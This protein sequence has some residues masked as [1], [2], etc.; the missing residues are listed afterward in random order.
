MVAFSI[1]L[2]NQPFING[3]TKLLGVIGDPVE[4]SL[5]PVMHNAAIAHLGVNYIYLPFPV[6]QD[7]LATALDGFAAIGVQGINLTI[8]HKQAVIPLLSE[9]T[10]VAQ[11]I[12]AVN[13]LWRTE[14][15]W[16]GTNTDAEGFIAPLK[17][18]NRDWSQVIP[19][20]LGNG[21]AARA[22]V[23]GCAELGCPEIG[24]VGRDRQKLDK[25]KQSWQNTPFKDRL[26]VHTW[27]KLS[28]M[29]SNTQLLVNTTPVGMSPKIEQSPVEAAL[30]QQLP[31]GAIAYDLIYTPSPTRFLQL[32]QQQ[33]VT[34]LD[35]S[36]MLIQQGAAALHLWLDTPIPVEIMRQALLDQL[37]I[38]GK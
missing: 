27:D 18:L 12:G 34:T 4:H 25:F 38:K 37:R 31:Q 5:S 10:P 17:A 9:I 20:I 32:A 8:P 6:R 35:G 11:A 24:V 1:I 22:V 26:S 13:T 21:G 2:M 7:A 23:A 19:L 14:T 16:S 15:G 28:E 33:G 3:K 36:E 30:L 29:V